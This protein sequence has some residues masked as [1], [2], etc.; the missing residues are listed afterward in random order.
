MRV[1]RHLSPRLGAAAFA[2]AVVMP[3]AGCAAPAAEDA[4][5]ADH[6]HAGGGVVTHW[7]GALELFVEYPPHVRGVASDPWDIHLTWLEGWQPVRE[8][9][10]TLLLRGPGGV[11]EEI[12]LDAPNPPG[13]YAPTATLSQSG[14]WRAD[15]TLVVAGET[16]ELPVGQL[17]V[18][19]TEDALPHDVETPPPGLIAFPKEQQWSVPFG[20]AVADER[21]IPGSIPVT[22][23][24]AAPGNGL[25][26]IST[27]V[28]GL[29]LVRGRRGW[30]GIRWRRGRRWP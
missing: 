30:R 20:V 24:I 3:Q 26:H 6:S 14:T 21:R 8:G 25:A 23:E 11:R 9:R 16:H 29:V 12:V 18:F 27:P 13:T 15:L 4:A 19:A 5:A 10:L 1:I 28:A 2:V 22:G 17:E 7:T